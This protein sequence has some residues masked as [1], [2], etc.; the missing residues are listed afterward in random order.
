MT[1]ETVSYDVKTQGAR[2][3]EE[4]F[5]GFSTFRHDHDR[6]YLGRTAKAL[7]IL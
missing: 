1:S 3:A 5:W 2:H 7:Y 6:R 4:Q